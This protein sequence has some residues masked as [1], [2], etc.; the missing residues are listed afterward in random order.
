[1]TDLQTPK[2][3][4]FALQML[5]GGY[6]IELPTGHHRINGVEKH[7]T[8]DVATFDELPKLEKISVKHLTTHYSNVSGEQL[9]VDDYNKKLEE[10]KSKGHYID[11]CSELKFDNLD[12]EYAFKKFVKEWIENQVIK[13]VV[14]TTYEFEVIPEIKSSSVYIVPM[15]HFGKD[16]TKNAFVLHRQ[17]AA[18]AAFLEFAK[19]YGYK[20]VG[21]NEEP[22]ENECQMGFNALRYSRIGKSY[23]FRGSDRFESN[24]IGDYDSCE[25]IMQSDRD[26]IEQTFLVELNANK[27]FKDE[28]TIKTILDKVES[29]QAIFKS[30]DYKISTKYQYDDTQKEISELIQTLTQLITKE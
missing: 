8:G 28:T 23:V 12:D 1:M 9:S 20:V 7:L 21:K 17:F 19:K 14:E 11:N 10:L 29:I 26:Y 5:N 24:F 27:K 15:R 3:K 13:T 16:I 22:R 4:L 6:M 2:T 30:V 18:E 25:E